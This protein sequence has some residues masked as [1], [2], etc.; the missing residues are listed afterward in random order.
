M[1]DLRGVGRK[2]RRL[3]ASVRGSRSDKA[4]AVSHVRDYHEPT[5][6]VACDAV[7]LR[8]TWR[9]GR[10]LTAALLEAMRWDACP[11]CRQ[12]GR[13][14]AFGRVRMRGTFTP[15][16]SEA[17]RRRIENV[18]ERARF[19]QPERRVLTVDRVQDA[20]EIRTTSQKLAHRI[21]TELAKAF[22]G[23]CAYSWSDQDGSLLAVWERDADGR[24]R[25]RARHP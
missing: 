2:K 14:E 16:E 3:G 7:F 19:T 4:P 22:G 1:K 24:R 5:R 6:C 11:A 10:R 12:I 25:R 8:K 17:I 23:R 18:S 9:V 13:R 15:S 21:A 20:L